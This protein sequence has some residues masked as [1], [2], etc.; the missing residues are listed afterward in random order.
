MGPQIPHF[1]KFPRDA[2]VARTGHTLWVLRVE[3]RAP[4]S[5]LTLSCREPVRD[6]SPEP[7]DLPGRPWTWGAGSPLYVG[8]GV[9]VQREGPEQDTGHHRSSVTAPD[10]GVL[11]L[12]RKL[13]GLC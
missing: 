2:G 5:S 11:L 8:R 3:P 6:A 10:L 13:P 7:P 9:L 4:R 12:H 1:Q